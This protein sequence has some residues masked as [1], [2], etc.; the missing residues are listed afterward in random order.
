[1]SSLLA[2]KEDKFVVAQDSSK[3]CAMLD[4]L[5]STQVHLTDFSVI[6]LLGDLDTPNI[7]GAFYYE[8]EHY[9]VPDCIVFYH[10][11]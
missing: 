5:C 3:I 8:D 9:S 6:I 4:S 10:L 2:M 7:Q 1:M 11:N